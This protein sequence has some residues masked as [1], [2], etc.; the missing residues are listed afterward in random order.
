MAS[1]P[2]IDT[3]DVLVEPFHVDFTGHIFLGV[4]GNHLLNAAGK[5]SQKRG[6][7]IGALNETSHMGALPPVHRD[8]RDAPAV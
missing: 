5:H 4:L 8:E 6:W 2:K 7:G 1:L 3:Y